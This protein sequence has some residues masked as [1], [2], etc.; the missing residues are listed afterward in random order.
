MKDENPM[1]ITYISNTLFSGWALLGSASLFLSTT[2][3]GIPGWLA[4]IGAVALFGLSALKQREVW[5]KAKADRRKADIEAK[6]AAQELKQ[7]EIE[8]DQAK[9]KAGLN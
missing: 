7:S 2:F 9:K 1:V 3:E 5:L 4:P 8:T 6:I